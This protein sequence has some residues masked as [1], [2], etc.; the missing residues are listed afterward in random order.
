M[1]WTTTAMAKSTKVIPEA[2]RPVSSVAPKGYVQTGSPIVLLDPWIV[3]QQYPPVS[4]SATVSTTTAT[5]WPTRALLR[6]SALFLEQLGSARRAL[7]AVYWVSNSAR[8]HHQPLRSATVS[9]ITATVLSTRAFLRRIA[10]FLEHRVF[11][12][13]AP[14]TAWQAWSS[15]RG[16]QRLPRCAMGSTTTATASSMMGSTAPRATLANLNPLV[17]Q[18]HECVSVANSAANPLAAAPGPVVDDDGALVPRS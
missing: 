15:A 9:T 8:G 17:K 12:R 3:A 7:P 13:R 4:R 18:A 16:R 14:A 1:A 5:A 11:A 10:S 6:R 2:G